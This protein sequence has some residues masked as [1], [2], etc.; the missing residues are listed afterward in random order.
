[1]SP[2]TSKRLR[3]L[4]A[5]TLAAGLAVSGLGACNALTGA[6]DILLKK[7]DDDD[8]DDNDDGQSGGSG[9]SGA[10]GGTGGTA[11]PGGTAGSAGSGGTAGSAGSGGTQACEWPQGPYGV[12]EGDTLPSSINWNGYRE[13]SST[14]EQISMEDLFDCDGT[15]G[16]HA[17]FFSTTQFGCPGCSQEA[18]HIADELAYW[19]TLGIKVIFLLLDNPGDGNPTLS[20][21]MQWRNEYGLDGAIVAPD[22]GFSMVPGYQVGTPQGTVVDPRTMYVVHLEEGYSGNFS[23][24]IN[25]AQQNA[26]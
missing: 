25:L 12:D 7:A 13:Y 2:T 1:M 24:L 10:T 15:R 17:L 18:A 4:L 5:A 3:S 26:P 6:E 19:E 9:G 14:D 20:G 23:Q 22:P 8:D 21:A 11:G 16:I